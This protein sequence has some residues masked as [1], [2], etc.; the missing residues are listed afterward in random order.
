MRTRSTPRSSSATG[1]S[2]SIS[3]AAARGA[4]GALRAAAAA[5][6][7]PCCPTSAP[8]GPDRPTSATAATAPPRSCSARPRRRGVRAAELLAWQASQRPREFLD[9]WRTPGEQRLSSLGGA[10]RARVVPAADQGR[11]APRARSRRARAGR[12]CGRS[13][14]RTRAPRRPR[15]RSEFAGRIETPGPAIGYAGAADLGVQLAAVLDRGRARRDDAADPR[16]RR[17]RRD[18]AADHRRAPG[19]AAPPSRSHAARRGR[20]VG[21]ATFLAWRGHDRARDAAPP[22]ARPPAGAAVGALGGVEVRVRRLALHR[23][24]AAST[25]RRRAS[26]A[27]AA[28]STRWSR[29][30]LAKQARDGRHVHGRPAR[31]L[32]LAADDRRRSSTS[33]AA[34]AYTLELTDASARPGARS[35]AR[36]EMTFRRLYTPGGVHNYFWKARPLSNGE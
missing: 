15:P 3:P 8:G 19:R 30:P 12:P 22:R 1:G 28:P 25:S 21:Y 4:V 29:A 2:R 24:A 36:V 18:R 9:R 14:R 35:A 7:W 23:R 27:A 17:V 26:A 6:A 20:D 13:P 10:L 34:A 33:T 31:V 16:R 11:G 5:A 32:A